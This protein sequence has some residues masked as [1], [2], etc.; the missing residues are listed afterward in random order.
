MRERR[1]LITKSVHTTSMSAIPGVEVTKFAPEGFEMWIT[2]LGSTEHMTPDVTALTEYKLA[3]SGDMVEVT[4]KILLP[5]QG[6]GGLTLELQQPGGITAVTLQ[7]VAHVL[8]LGCNLLSTRRASE[9]SGEP[10]INYPNKAQLGLGKN[11]I[12]TF[13]LGESGFFEVMG[14]RCNH[15]N[16]ALSLRA[17]LSRG[18]MGMR[19]LLGHSSEQITRD[20][21]KKLGVKLSGPW[22]PCVACSKA[23]ARRN[24]VPKSTYTRSTRRAGRFFVDLGGSMPATSLGSSKYVMI[25]VDDFSRFKLVRF[26]KTKSDAAAAL[27]NIIA[28]YITRAGLKIGSL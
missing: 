23:K 11:T 17:L 5:F 13:R 22:T 9:R 24:A 15:E 12:C 16:R 26:L 8:A 20:T 1:T 27:R 19:R 7:K 14:R 4:D 6:Y 2:D 3:A 21:A 10:F 18:V 25:R 28:E